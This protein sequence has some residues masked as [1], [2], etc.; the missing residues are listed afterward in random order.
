MPC[1]QSRA[2]SQDAWVRAANDAFHSSPT[3]LPTHSLFPHTAQKPPIWA[4]STISSDVS[5]V[6]T[7]PWH[8]AHCSSGRYGKSG[9]TTDRATLYN[10]KLRLVQ[11]LPHLEPR[12]IVQ[13]HTNPVVKINAPNKRETC[14]IP[15]T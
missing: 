5:S 1:L 15:R 11:P 2:R 10:L 7:T 3:L 14:I 6:D 9:K 12:L 4:S 13:V 8:A